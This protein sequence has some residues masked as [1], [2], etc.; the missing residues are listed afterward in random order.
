MLIG[1]YAV[2]IPAL[3]IAGSLGGKKYTP[4]SAGT[5]ATDNTVFVLL[6]IGVIIIVGG[7]TFFP[8]LSLGSIAE[9]LIMINRSFLF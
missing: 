8:A 9:H 4:P 3:L 6:L 1:R 5:F 2:I 7:L